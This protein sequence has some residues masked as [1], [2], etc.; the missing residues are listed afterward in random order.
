MP[1]LAAAMMVW[2]GRGSGLVKAKP[3]AGICLFAALVST[4]MFLAWAIPANNATGGA[5]AQRGLGDQLWH[6]LFT[7]M[8]SHGGG[9]LISLPFYVPVVI[10]MFVPWTL[11]LPGSLSATLGGRIG[12]Q[13]G[14]AFLIGWIVPT[15]VL[16][17]VV[18]TKLPHY[19]LAM[20]PAMAI[21]C[22]ATLDEADRGAL[23]DRD[24]KWLR[25]GRV[26][27]GIPAGGVALVLMITPWVIDAQPLRVPGLIAGGVLLVAVIVACRLQRRGRS[28]PKPATTY[29]C[30]RCISASRV[31]CFMSAA[32][33]WSRCGRSSGCMN[34]SA[35]PARPYSSPAA[36]RSM[37]TNAHMAPRR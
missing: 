4:V 23:T 17:S 12:G 3:F 6:R 20:W 35:N 30:T 7:P 18:A 32:R 24:M 1:L 15:F 33:R 2:M 34:G 5:F 10:G 16:M 14:K 37:I 11:H 13:R 25:L 36:V 21:M 22:A 29:R 19:V 8:E 26:F 28:A 27:F 31:W 9:F